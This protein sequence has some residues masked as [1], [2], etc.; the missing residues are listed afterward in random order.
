MMATTPNIAETK[1]KNQMKRKRAGYIK[2]SSH[3]KNNE[4]SYSLPT[5][6]AINGRMKKEPTKTPI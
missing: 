3:Y 5:Q 6:T 2:P 4:Y 1:S